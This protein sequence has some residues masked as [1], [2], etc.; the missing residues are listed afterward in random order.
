MKIVTCLQI[1]MFQS[2][3]SNVLGEFQAPCILYLC[4]KANLFFIS[5][6]TALHVLTFF[7]T[8][9]FFSNIGTLLQSNLVVEYNRKQPKRFQN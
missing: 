1:G 2:K 4:P 5:T 9:H 7:N 8:N 6:H 3:L